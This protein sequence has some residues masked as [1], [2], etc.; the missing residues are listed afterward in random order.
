MTTATLTI[1]LTAIRANWRALN[2]MTSCETAAVVKANAYGLGSSTVARALAQEGVRKFCV[3][4]AEEGV[5]VRKAIGPDIPIFIFSGHMAGDTDL[6]RDY[7]LTPMINSVDQ[8]IRHAENLPNHPFGIQLDTGMNRLGMEPVEWQAIR[9]MAVRLGP[10]LIMSHLACA[11][12]PN[13][14][15]NERQLGVFRDL[16]DGLDLPRSLSATG[17]ILLG[18]K[19]HFDLTRPGVGLYGGMPYQKAKPVVNITL[20]VIQIREVDTG[21]TVGYSNT[22][23]A[24]TPRRIATVSAGYADGI[25][26]AMGPNTRLFHKDVGCPIVGRISMDLIGVD[27]TLLSDTPRQLELLNTHQTVDILANNA[28]TIGYEV[29]TS[30]GGRYRRKYIGDLS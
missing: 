1:D 15:M 9:D 5:S 16:T 26:R 30:L 12:D 21:E 7:A 6:I 2:A 4:V 20:P 27:V 28:G 11:D 22:W 8:L 25:I 13:H 29:L 17:G 18:E 23:T 24:P 14:D 10:K 19:Y 3:A